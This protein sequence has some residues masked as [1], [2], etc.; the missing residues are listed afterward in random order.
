MGKN[1]LFTCLTSI[2]VTLINLPVLSQDLN[3]NIWPQFRG[4]NCSGVAQPGQIPPVDLESPE[5]LIWKSELLPGASSP[6]IWGDRIFLTGFDKEN[7]Q[8]H[9]MC[10]NRLNGK[11]LWNRIVPAKEIVIIRK[12]TTMGR[13][14]GR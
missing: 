4:I 14:I 1:L 2:S 5:K 9:V 6:C 13:I 8:L 3:K 7:Q 11:Q 12:Y 10:F